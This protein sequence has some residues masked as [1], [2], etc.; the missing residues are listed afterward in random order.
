MTLVWTQT[1]PMVVL[2]LPW[3]FGYE[4][5]QLLVDGICTSIDVG[6]NETTSVKNN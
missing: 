4:T 5:P 3:L 1:A 6:A 2:E